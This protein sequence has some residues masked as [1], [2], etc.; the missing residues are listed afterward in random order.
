MTNTHFNKGSVAKAAEPLSLPAPGARWAYGAKKRFQMERKAERDARRSFSPADELI[1][2]MNDLPVLG[3]IVINDALV[4][5]QITATSANTHRAFVSDVRAFGQ[6]CRRRSRV[7]LPASPETV[8]DYLSARAAGELS[9]KSV[10]KGKIGASAA[11]L[12]RYRASIAR[13]HSLLDLADPTKSKLVELTLKGLRRQIGTA[14]RQ[15]APLRYRGPVKDVFAGKRRGVSVVALLDSCDDT[16][17][18]LRDRALLSLGYDTGLRPS[19]LVAVEIGHIAPASD[20]DAAMLTIPRSKGDQVGEGATAYLSPRTVRAVR[21]WLSSAE[22]EDGPVFRRVFV[23]HIKA[24]PAVRARSV[25]SMSSR[26]AFD[27]RRLAAKPAEPARTVYTVGDVPLTPQSI[28][29]IYRAILKRAYDAGLLSHLSK[30]EFEHWSKA[31]SGHS[32]RVGLNQDL[33]VAGEDLAGIMDAL[34]WK[35]A[36]MPLTYNRNLAAESGAAG[37]LLSKLD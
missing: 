15:A 33:F 27:L 6:W 37:R 19:E 23:R 36:R 3:T 5:A 24:R 8:S 22:I 1:G 11:S 16:L 7:A 20:P 26:M 18:G 34:R 28:T 35:S 31:I 9:S 13:L 4:S 10:R 32:T 29:P 2:V 17:V 14:Q 21:A 25:S 12:S 30:D